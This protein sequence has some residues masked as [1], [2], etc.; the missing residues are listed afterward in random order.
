M[1]FFVYSPTN[2]FQDNHSFSFTNVLPCGVC[3]VVYHP[4]HSLLILGSL[5]GHGQRN[6]TGELNLLP[7]GVCP[8][9]Y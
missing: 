3:S 9:F 2:G 7:F 1:F 4:Q 5:I 8:K 6:S